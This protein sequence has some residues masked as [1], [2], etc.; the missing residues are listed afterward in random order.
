MYSSFPRTWCW[1]R[2]TSGQCGNSFLSV[3]TG[4]KSSN[5]EGSRR[6][7]TAPK[8]FS[9][10]TGGLSDSKHWHLTTWEWDS[11]T[12]SLKM[13]RVNTVCWL[14][15][16]KWHHQHIDWLSVIL[17][18]TVLCGLPTRLKFLAETNYGAEDASLTVRDQ[19]SIGHCIPRSLSPGNGGATGITVQTLARGKEQRRWRR[20][21]WE[22][23]V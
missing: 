13:T 10:L 11:S 20:Q 15:G 18:F 23:E 17:A 16:E 14:A 4:A 1:A 9:C 2:R 6:R 21:R 19:N 22:T 8:L 5:R 3:Q 7:S 12:F